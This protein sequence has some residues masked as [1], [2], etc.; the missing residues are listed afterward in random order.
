MSRGIVRTMQP[1]VVWLGVTTASASAAHAVPGTWRAVAGATGAGTIPQALVAACATGLALSLAW[2]W[3]VTSVTVAEVVA[4]AVPRSGGATRRLVLLACGAAA[5]AGTTVPAQASGG[6]GVEVLVGLPLPERAVTPAPTG[7]QGAPATA[8]TARSYVVRSGDSLWS[9]ARGHPAAGTDVETR[10]R[11]IWHH[12]RDVVGNDPDLIHPGQS[13]RL[14]GT[15]I[16]PSTEPAD[17]KDGE[18]S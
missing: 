11:A 17:D 12:N 13:L 10:W 2:L 14:P 4:G 15:D 8:P 9:I 5:V 1:Y 18:P 6:D 3:L 16:D 7:R